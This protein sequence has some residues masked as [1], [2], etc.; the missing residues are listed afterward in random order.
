MRYLIY[1]FLRFRNG[2]FLSTVLLLSYHGYKLSKRDLRIGQ[3][4]IIKEKENVLSPS[5]KLMFL[6]RVILIHCC[7]SIL[8]LSISVKNFGS[9]AYSLKS[10]ISAL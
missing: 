9:S 3:K 2:V 10:V 5:W 7:I 4:E 6:N 8:G 1:L